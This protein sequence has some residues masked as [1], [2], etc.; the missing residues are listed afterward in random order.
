F[1][2]GGAPALV[3]GIIGVVASLGYAGGPNP[4]AKLGLA[5][6]VFFIMFGIVAVVGT[7]YAQAA[8]LYGAGFARHA[9]LQALPLSAFLIGLPIGALVT[10][11]L[12][13]DDMRDREFDA[14]K[15]W[16]TG[17]VRFGIGWSRIRYVL[18]SIVAY[19]APIWF[20]VG[21]EFSG[22]VLLPLLTLPWAYTLARAVCTKDQ[23]DD[24]LPMTPR[25]SFL[26]FFYSVLL[27]VG[28]AVS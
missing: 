1:H 12:I 15:G 20:W 2:I 10:N 17:A 4:Y 3:I 11:I 27:A 19:L 16:R 21:L 22:W 7:Y 14:M 23:S 13:I 18:L 8:P 26:S 24:L 9:A 25:A 5:E 6:P 28:I